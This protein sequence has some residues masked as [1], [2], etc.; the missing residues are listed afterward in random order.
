MKFGLAG[1][2]LLEH[3]SVN[4]VVDDEL[5]ANSTYYFRDFTVKG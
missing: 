2:V 1:G 4:D 5:E 3:E